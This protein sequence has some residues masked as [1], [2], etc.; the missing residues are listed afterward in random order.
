MTHDKASYI[1]T[2][3]AEPG[4]ILGDGEVMPE[5]SPDEINEAYDIQ[6]QEVSEYLATH[7]FEGFNQ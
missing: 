7:K 6:F 3:L 4:L 1:I 2:I 5:F